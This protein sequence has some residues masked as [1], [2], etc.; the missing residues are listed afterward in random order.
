MNDDELEQI[1]GKA[2]KFKALRRAKARAEP[3][4]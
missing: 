1:M 4:K 3:A 2:R